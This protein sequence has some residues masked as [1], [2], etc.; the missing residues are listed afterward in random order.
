MKFDE[1]FSWFRGD[2]SGLYRLRQ[3]RWKK[4][5]AYHLHVAAAGRCCCCCLRHALI[6]SFN[7]IVENNRSQSREAAAGASQWENGRRFLSDYSNSFSDEMN[8][9]W[10]STRCSA[11]PAEIKHTPNAVFYCAE[12][13][14]WTGGGEANWRLAVEFLR[15]CRLLCLV[16]W[17]AG[18]FVNNCAEMLLL[19][20]SFFFTFSLLLFPLWIVMQISFG[21]YSILGKLGKIQ[22]NQIYIF[23]KIQKM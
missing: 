21:F 12:R 7:K 3:G 5:F 9:H 19:T 20:G 14:K 10:M 13:H 4:L 15:R 6:H 18:P 1:I 22:V 17:S 8:E 23:K 11:Q 16:T 2:K